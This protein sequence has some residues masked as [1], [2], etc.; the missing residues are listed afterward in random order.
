MKLTLSPF[1]L[2]VAIL[3]V[4]ICFFGSTIGTINNVTDIHLPKSDIGWFQNRV[5]EAIPYRNS[6]VGSFIKASIAPTQYSNY[7]TIRTAPPVWEKKSSVS[8]VFPIIFFR[9]LM[10]IIIFSYFYQ[11]SRNNAGLDDLSDFCRGAYY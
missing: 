3:L 5:D 6:F 1:S 8:I 7:F 9:P 11:S 10:V 4:T 2:V